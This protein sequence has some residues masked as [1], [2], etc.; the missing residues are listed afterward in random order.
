MKRL[1]YYGKKVDFDLKIE[2]NDIKIYC[3]KNLED[4]CREFIEYYKKDILRVKKEL[5]INKKTNFIVALVD[6]NE[7]VNFVYGQSDFS[8]YF[9]DTGAY[10]YI[11]LNG[12]K[13]KE[14]MFKGLIHELVHHL[15]KYYLY[16]KDKNRITWVDEGIA[17]FISNQKE[18]LNDNDKFYE[19]LKI[20]L[21]K[22]NNINLNELNHYDRSFGYKN[23]YNLSYIAI[24]YL[25]E[26]NSHQ[27]FLNIIKD[28]NELM[29]L[30]ESILSEIKDN[31]NIKNKLK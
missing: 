19:F 4:F 29:K 2:E 5:G 3:S 6:N 31:Y 22:N 13:S 14:Y 17:T 20:N 28:E 25:Y 12:K 8:G 9:N 11:N 15:Y 30:G 16:G 21:D 27:E 10:A 1:K 24:R 7:E 18:E 26:I 23:G